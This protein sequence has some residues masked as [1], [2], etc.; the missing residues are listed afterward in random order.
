MFGL[1][2]KKTENRDSANNQ[3]LNDLLRISHETHSGEIVNQVNCEGIPAVY[4]AVN[5]IS[6]AIAAMPIHT[7]ARLSNGD[8]QRERNNLERLLNVAPNP[9]QSAYNFKVALLR[10]TLLTGNG[11]A[12]IIYANDGTVDKLIP[13]HPS[14]VQVK[15]LPDHRLGYQ[16]TN[17]G[18]Y[19]TLLQ[20]QIL[21]IRVNSDDGI[22][23]KSPITACR[24]ALGLELATQSHASQ[25]FKSGTSVSGFL[26]IDKL[27]TPEQRSSLRERYQDFTSGKLRAGSFGVLEMN[28]DYQP[29]SMTNADAEFVESRK[30]GIAEVARM[31]KI[32]PL[33][34]MDYSNSTYSNFAEASKAFLQQT[35]KPWVTNLESALLL[36]LVPEPQQLNTVIE[37]ETKDV[38]RTTAKERYELYDIAIRNG[39]MSPNEARRT[40]NL[41]P[42]NGGDEFSQ[43]WLN[44]S[45]II[46]GEQDV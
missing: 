7:Y 17:D 21:H 38:L 5:T 23:G 29:I 44:Q 27:L 24:E 19:R 30:L 43:S 32:S 42:R 9:M 26:K 13:L 35:I 36:A 25:T 18:K 20:E 16:V 28:M 22:I 45:N 3:L 14:S 6:E 15:Q 31:F 46:K 2:K 10:S 11:Y 4:C 40:E 12:E 34:L 39:L 41:P 8:K 33:Y 37:F 1:F